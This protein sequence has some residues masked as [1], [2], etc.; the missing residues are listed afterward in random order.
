MRADQLN[1]LY[2]HSV[3]INCGNNPIGAAFWLGYFGDSFREPS[4]QAEIQNWLCDLPDEN[5][6]NDP[7]VDWWK[8]RVENTLI[9]YRSHFWRDGI[10]VDVRL[11]FGL[12][13]SQATN[14]GYRVGE[15]RP[16][17]RTLSY[18]FP[19]TRADHL[20]IAH[21]VFTYSNSIEEIFTWILAEIDAFTKPSSDARHVPSN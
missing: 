19:W 10:P 6:V 5:E 20:A 14:E 11:Y 4:Y 21:K 15:E 13:G 9:Y 17:E 16:E 2:R 3:G 18:V 7:R 12:D 1:T 8:R